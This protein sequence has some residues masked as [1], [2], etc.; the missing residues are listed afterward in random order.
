MEAASRGERGY[1]QKWISHRMWEK[2]WI[3]E[4]QESHAR[5]VESFETG[6]RGL[7]K[8]FW[9]TSDQIQGTNRSLG[10]T[11]VERHSALLAERFPRHNQTLINRIKRGQVWRSDCWGHS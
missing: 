5:L 3:R 10:F 6:E 1:Y 11:A 8:S 4:F 7:P 9:I 2:P